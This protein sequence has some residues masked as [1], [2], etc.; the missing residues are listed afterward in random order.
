MNSQDFIPYLKKFIEVTLDDGTK[1]A[2]YITNPEAFKDE[3]CAPAHIELI[4]GLMKS[5]VPVARVVSI[6][7]PAREDTVELPVIANPEQFLN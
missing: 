2:G 1:T 4:N 3:S 5:S 6:G 7:L